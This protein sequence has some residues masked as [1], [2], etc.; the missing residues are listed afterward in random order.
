MAEPRP[1]QCLR[2]PE[3]SEAFNYRK[4][5]NVRLRGR[6]SCFNKSKR[7]IAINW[8]K[9]HVWP[10]L[11]EA[12]AWCGV[13]KSLTSEVAKGEDLTCQRRFS[14]FWG[15]R[16]TPGPQVPGWWP[17]QILLPISEIPQGVASIV[18]SIFDSCVCTHAPFY[19]ISIQSRAP[20]N[21]LKA[22]W[23]FVFFFNFMTCMGDLRNC[24]P[25]FRVLLLFHFLSEEQDESL[26]SSEPWAV[27]FLISQ[28]FRSITP[29]GF[30]KEFFPNNSVPS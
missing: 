13:V 26:S 11:R 7:W 28:A 23:I 12:T 29:W 21:T 27:F 22:S 9:A 8:P 30:I 5:D 16:W 3:C 4:N 2:D 10:H 1:G 17:F 15:F 18:P 20:K 14:C 6:E 25:P 24:L 19:T